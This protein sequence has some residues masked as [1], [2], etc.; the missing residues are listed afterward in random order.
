MHS[1]DD[2][3]VVIIEESDEDVIIIEEL[4]DNLIILDLNMIKFENK[5]SIIGKQS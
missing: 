5:T 2:S 3:D 4:E 1:Q